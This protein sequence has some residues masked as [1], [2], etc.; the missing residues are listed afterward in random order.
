MARYQHGVMVPHRRYYFVVA[1]C[2]KEQ[3][4]LLDGLSC[5]QLFE[6]LQLA[7]SNDRQLDISPCFAELRKCSNGVANPL[8][9]DQA[10]DIE[11]S[12]RFA[13]RWSSLG[14]ITAW[15]YQSRPIERYYLCRVN[16]YASKIERS[17]QIV[18]R[19][20]LDGR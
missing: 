16:A 3:H 13:K 7:L 1:P 17:C 15:R 4:V 20:D 10:S 18:V 8:R 14:V 9:F 2:T 19:D 12:K 11:Q 6:S 5:R